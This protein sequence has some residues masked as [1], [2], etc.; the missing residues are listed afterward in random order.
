MIDAF[1]EFFVTKR[2]ASIDAQYH[3]Q[4]D[5]DLVLQ[6]AQK[7]ISLFSVMTQER[8]AKSFLMD[9]FS[10]SDNAGDGNQNI[11]KNM[12]ESLIA[13]ICLLAVKQTLV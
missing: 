13:P 7:I 10:L 6:V 4:C 1:R 12:I 11:L 2:G 5:K 8:V 9:T 3:H